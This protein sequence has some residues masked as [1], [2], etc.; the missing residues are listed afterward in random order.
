MLHLILLRHI[1]KQ[2]LKEYNKFTLEYRQRHQSSKH[3]QILSRKQNLSLR[4]RHGKYITE[5]VIKLIALDNQ[6]ISVVEDQGFFH[7]LEFL[8]SWYAL[9]SRHYTTLNPI[10]NYNV[11]VCALVLWVS[12]SRACKTGNQRDAERPWNR[13]ATRLFYMTT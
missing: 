7:H 6:L 8:N 12:Y 11:S 3:L 10:S 5:K 4:Q 13:Q 9:P 1:K 2:T